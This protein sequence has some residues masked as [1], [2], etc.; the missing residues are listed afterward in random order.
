MLIND[1]LSINIQVQDG[2]LAL[3]ENPFPYSKRT[4]YLFSRS[5]MSDF[6]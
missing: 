3:A 5:V 2:G 6:L 4:K 1:I